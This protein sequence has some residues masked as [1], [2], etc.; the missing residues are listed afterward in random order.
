MGKAEANTEENMRKNPDYLFARANYAEIFFTRQE[1]DKIPEIFDHAYDL[2]TL[3]PKR[4]RL[5]ITEFVN[6]MGL[7]AFVTG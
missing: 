2:Q 7:R 1:Y 4:K 3:Y 6:F 5:H